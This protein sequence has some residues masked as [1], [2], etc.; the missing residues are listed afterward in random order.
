MQGTDTVMQDTLSLYRTPVP[1]NFKGS[2]LNFFLTL[3]IRKRLCKF[4]FFSKYLGMN[5]S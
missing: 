5:K 4:E 3:T 2:G 1:I